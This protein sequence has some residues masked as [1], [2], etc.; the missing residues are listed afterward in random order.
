MRYLFVC[1]TEFQIL[2][3][4][5]IKYHLLT[6][7]DADIIIR[8]NHKADSDI[9]KR[10]EKSKLFNNIF[11]FTPE[12]EGIHAYIRNLMYNK[13]GVSFLDAFVNEVKMF[14]RSILEYMLGEDY[15]LDSN[16]TEYRKLS[17]KE[18][19]AVFFQTLDHVIEPLLINIKRNNVGCK[20]NL[21]DEGTMSYFYSKVER[22]ALDCIYLYEPRLSVCYNE[23]V[24]FVK[25]PKIDKREKAFINLINMIFNWRDV[26]GEEINNAVIFFDQGYQAMPPYLK[27]PNWAKKIVFAN[28]YKKHLRLATLYESEVD[29]FK[30]IIGWV[31]DKKKYIKFHPRTWYSMKDEFQDDDVYIIPNNAIPWEVIASNLNI[32]NSI[33]VTINSSSAC[34]Y[35]A[36]V[37]RKEDNNFYILLDQLVQAKDGFEDGMFDRLLKFYPQNL[38]IPNTEE[39]L[40]NILDDCLLKITK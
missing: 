18:Y 31:N 11:S 8:N 32:K 37:G 33:F 13:D 38:F 24:E 6:N 22:F 14:K 20:L 16:I 5:N 15:I 4:L 34:L 9:I 3:A 1:V 25:I 12:Q 29:W 35:E 30:K 7:D 23:E 21:L 19:D 39:E 26:Y 28:P 10:I 40:R 36:V 27:N 17:K 2:S